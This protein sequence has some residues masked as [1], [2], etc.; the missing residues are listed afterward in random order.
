[1]R[2]MLVF[3]DFLAPRFDMHDKMTK[4]QPLPK[5][6]VMVRLVRA[7]ALRRRGRG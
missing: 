6:L 1:M 3:Q 2:T 4:P 5:R 7:Q